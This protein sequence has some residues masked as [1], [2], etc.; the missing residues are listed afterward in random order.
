M[1]DILNKEMDGSDMF[2]SLGT[3]AEEMT[4]DD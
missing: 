4:K 3:D 1:D 2:K